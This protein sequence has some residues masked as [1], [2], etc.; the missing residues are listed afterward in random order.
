MASDVAA[1]VAA[2]APTVRR[3]RPTAVR[4]L[5]WP[6]L[7]LFALFFVLPFAVLGIM[8]LLSGNPVNA[9]AVNLTLR[10]FARFFSDDLYLEALWATLRIGLITTLSALLL[11]YPLAHL[12]AR[13]RSRVG[14]ALLLMAVIA[15]M[16]TGIVVRTFA[17]MTLLQ[18]RGVINTTLLALG[19]THEPLKLM[20]NEFGTI[21]ALT[22]IYVPFMVLTL[23]GVIGRVDERLEEAARSLGA[24]RWQAFREVTLPLSLPGI[25][26]G[27]LL[28]FALSISAYVTPFLMG[29]TDVLTLPMLIYQQV[30]SSFN[31]NF[32]GALGV[33]LLAV[34]LVLVIAYNK[35]LAGLSGEE[36]LS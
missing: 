28:V 10:H 33:I 25:L 34:S 4:W 26:A 20:Y 35:V 12:M 17:W 6:A 1:R 8:S 9:P 19:V 16:L 36:G 18:D 5:I 22:H 32:A 23:A 27:S 7:L 15:P 31:P 14:H 3:A 29:G 21:V 2:P 24:T 13:A 30:S 11:G